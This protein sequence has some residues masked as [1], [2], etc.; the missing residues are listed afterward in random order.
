VDFNVHPAKREVKFRTPHKIHQLI[1]RIIKPDVNPL[2]V[3][4]T[5]TEWEKE[6][7]STFETESIFNKDEVFQFL[8]IGNAIL[9]FPQ[10]DGMV[11][12]DYH[13]AHE[14]INFEKF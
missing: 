13:A 14:R 2:F 6:K 11:F 12:L 4:E 7:T 10:A 8:N 5:I 9:A 1:F 3:G